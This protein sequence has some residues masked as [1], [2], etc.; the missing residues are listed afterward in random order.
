MQ[1][2][3]SQI[4]TIKLH[5]ALKRSYRMN[6]NKKKIHISS[7]NGIHDNLNIPSFHIENLKHFEYFVE[8]F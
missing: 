3:F 7:L 2:S 1:Q 5:K 4:K 8:F 6:N